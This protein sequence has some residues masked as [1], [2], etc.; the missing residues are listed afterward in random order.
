M[1]ITGKTLP[2]ELKLC[3]ILI[4]KCFKQPLSDYLQLNSLSSYDILVCTIG[5]KPMLKER[6]LILRDLWVAGLRADIYLEAM[7][8]N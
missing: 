6:M 1:I 5:H 3:Q 2:L 8:V 7:Q 4:N